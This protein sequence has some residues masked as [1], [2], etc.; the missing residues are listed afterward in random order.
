MINFV[1]LL[2]MARYNL[3]LLSVS[4]SLIARVRVRC[5]I[6][7][8][9]LRRTWN[10][11]TVP[12]LSS[13]GRPLGIRIRYGTRA[14]VLKCWVR[15]LTVEVTLVLRTGGCSVAVILCI[16]RNNRV[17]S[18]P[19]SPKCLRNLGLSRVQVNLYTDALSPNIANTRFSLLRILWVTCV[20]LLLCM[21]LRRVDN[22]CSR[23][24][25]SVSLSLTCP[26]LSTL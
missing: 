24:W 19:T 26:S 7:A 13:S 10:S 17:T 21:S 5:T 2:S 14:C 23:L 12:V 11:L 22:L 16:N 18:C 8:S 20:P 3:L 9:V 6:P 15:Y 25:E 1:L 4:A